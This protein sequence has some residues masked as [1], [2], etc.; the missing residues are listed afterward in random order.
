MDKVAFLNKVSTIRDFT[1][2]DGDYEDSFIFQLY[3]AM[4][5][6]CTTLQ[7]AQML[8]KDE[9]GLSDHFAFLAMKKFCKVVHSQNIETIKCFLL[10]GI[11]ALFEPKGVSSWTISGLTMRLVIGLGLHRALSPRRVQNTDLKEVEMRSRVFWS[12]YC[13]ERL[14]ATSLGRMSAIE[15]DEITARYRNHYIQRN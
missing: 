14:V 9:E 11:F 3:M 4:A 6:G 1:A 13:F 5:I 12:A 15:D 10:L 7:R 2:M 8:T